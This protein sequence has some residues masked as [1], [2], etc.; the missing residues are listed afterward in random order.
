MTNQT[1]FLK[2]NAG[3]LA[4]LEE[5]SPR[6][7]EP[8]RLVKAARLRGGDGSRCEPPLAVLMHKAMTRGPAPPRVRWTQ[9]SRRACNVSTADVVTRGM[10]ADLRSR[11][12]DPSVVTTFDHVET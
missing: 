9:R 2:K 6:G 5:R 4:S 12:S 1:K 7:T 8:P 3:L 10:G 11:K